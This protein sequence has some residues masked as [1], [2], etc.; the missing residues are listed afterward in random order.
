MEIILQT[1]R[2]DGIAEQRF[3]GTPLQAVR[4]GIDFGCPPGRQISDFVDCSKC[5]CAVLQN[6]ADDFV[7]TFL[8]SA[9]QAANALEVELDFCFYGRHRSERCMLASTPH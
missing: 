9:D 4:T 1:S 5:N 8:K 2:S 6:R 7:P 3:V